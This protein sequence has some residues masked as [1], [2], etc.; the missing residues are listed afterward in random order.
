MEGN[1]SNWFVVF[2]FLVA[3]EGHLTCLMWLAKH[4]GTAHNDMT[5]DGMT[6][7]HAA[8][9]EGHLECMAFLLSSAG[10]SALARDR[11]AN[12]PLHYGTKADSRF[13]LFVR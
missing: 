12:T 7:T 11:A 6:A 9:F 4:S 2:C 3:Q 1:Y 10:C 13:K 5:V 8:A